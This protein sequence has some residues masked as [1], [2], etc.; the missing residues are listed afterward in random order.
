MVWR[1]A[2]W[3]W[4]PLP[5]SC[6]GRLT[7]AA[8]LFRR[9]STP[10]RCSGNWPMALRECPVRV[11]ASSSNRTRRASARAVRPTGLRRSLDGL[12]K[13]SSDIRRLALHGEDIDLSNQS[14]RGVAFRTNLLANNAALEATRAGSAGRTFG[15][16]AEEIRRLAD[17]SASTSDAIGARTADLA[18]EVAAAV[19]AIDEVSAALAEAMREAEAGEQAASHLGTAAAELESASRSLRPALEEA[20]AVAERRSARDQ[21]LSATLERFLQDRIDMERALVVHHRDTRQGRGVARTPGAAGRTTPP[22]RHARPEPPVLISDA[23]RGL[24]HVSLEV[25]DE[26]RCHPVAGRSPFTGPPFRA[27]GARVGSRRSS[28]R[29][30]SSDSACSTASPRC[31]AKASGRSSAGRSSGRTRRA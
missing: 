27:F 3:N 12:R 11:M 16:L 28:S 5:S 24:P 17:A 19:N 22:C 14:V 10:A 18:G 21:H 4:A 9:L 23:G 8:W 6:P 31:T 1:A 26:V 25:R 2:R 20:N 15:V 29:S 7:M 13:L 30:A